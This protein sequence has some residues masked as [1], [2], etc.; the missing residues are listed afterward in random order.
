MPSLPGG[1]MPIMP[2]LPD[3]HTP[4]SK[5]RRGKPCTDQTQQSSSR[6]RKAIGKNMPMRHIIASSWK[7]MSV[8][9]IIAS[10]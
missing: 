7:N 5:A 3:G 8:R 4:D 9:A 10:S 2:S 6:A 1:K